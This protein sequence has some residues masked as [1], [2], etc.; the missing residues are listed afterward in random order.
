MAAKGGSGKDSVKVDVVFGRVGT[1]CCPEG[2]LVGPT[3]NRST[4]VV[5]DGIYGID[6]VSGCNE[7]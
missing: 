4:G 6:R 5:G 3:G 1:A 2:G 7:S